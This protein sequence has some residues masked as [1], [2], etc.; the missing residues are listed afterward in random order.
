MANPPNVNF[1]KANMVFGYISRESELYERLSE[2]T[3]MVEKKNGD[4]YL[5]APEV[6]EVVVRLSKAGKDV[7]NYTKAEIL[8]T[9]RAVLDEAGG[10]AEAAPEEETEPPV[11]EEAPAAEEPVEEQPAEEED[12]EELPTPPPPAPKAVA[13]AAPKAVVAAPKA[14]AAPATPKPV[15]AAPKAPALAVAPKAPAPAPAVAKA[16]VAAPKAPVAVSKAP[17]AAPKA[18]AAAP[19][20]VAPAPKAAAPASVQEEASGD[21]SAAEKKYTLK[22]AKPIVVGFVLLSAAA[23]FIAEDGTE[24][25]QDR[26][27]KLAT[28]V[29]EFESLLD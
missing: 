10:A 9:T 2:A 23:G 11:E 3:V 26:R 27:D 19:K 21:D 8:D 14:V 24:G 12:P 22:E 29:A 13:K 17:A 1:A 18:P 25:A 15:A 7:S 16:P 20:A 6:V 5:F 28:L 4:Q